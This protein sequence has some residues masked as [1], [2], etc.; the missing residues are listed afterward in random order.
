MSETTPKTLVDYL[1]LAEGFLAG[2]GIDSSRIDAEL[3]LGHAVGLG[4]VELY[5]NHDRPLAD[6]EVEEFR[7]L[8]RRRAA[9]EPVAYITGRREF[10]SLDFRVDRR[11][12]IPRPETEFVVDAALSIL[13][14]EPP[15]RVRDNGAD[16]STLEPIDSP[17]D[18]EAEDD[19]D[20]REKPAAESPS[21]KLVR[22]KID[23]SKI[24]EIGT[25]SGAIAVSLAVELPESKIIATDESA[26]VLE[27]A[28][29]NAERHGVSDR[30][31]FRQGNV[32]DPISSEE[33]FDIIVSNP[34]YCLDRELDEMEPE[35]REWEPRGALVSG[36]DGME[37]TRRL[38]AHAADYLS[39]DGWLVLEAGSQVDEVK[40]AFET[41]GWREIHIIKDLAQRDRVV[42][43]KRPPSKSS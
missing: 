10:W 42:A 7:Q 9:R 6:T 27:V 5:T 19:L 31:E 11:V 26:A 15:F 35:V 8:L 34:P 1:K 33:S 28:P 38:I 18:G 36:E 16:E 2:K 12:L 40:A 25:G 14:D 24:L 37:V 21:A 17:A 3:L 32:F 39:G 30:I 29:S 4:R 22:A 20:D 41:A 13:R 23:A 43:G